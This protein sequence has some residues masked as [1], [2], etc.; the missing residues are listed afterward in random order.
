M[1]VNLNNYYYYYFRFVPHIKLTGFRCID[2]KRLPSVSHGQK[3]LIIHF[4]DDDAERLQA[5]DGDPI[6]AGQELEELLLVFIGQTVED[7]PEVDNGRVI[8]VITLLETEI[9][10]NYNWKFFFCS[11]LQVFTQ[12][13]KKPHFNG[14]NSILRKD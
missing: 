4:L 7:G 14:L 1:K 10:I 9:D 8:F 2:Q 6:G 13:Q 11:V 3:V 5:E 12:G